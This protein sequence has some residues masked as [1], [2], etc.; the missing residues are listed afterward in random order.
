MELRQ[1]PGPLRSK[2]E[3][4]VADDRAASN[5][6]WT[7]IKCASTPYESVEDR[8][9]EIRR[10]FS[11]DSKGLV[12]RGRRSDPESPPSA[13]SNDHDLLVSIPPLK[14]SERTGTITWIARLVVLFMAVAGIC[15][16][17]TR[18]M[19]VPP[20]PP[21]PQTL[22][23]PYRFGGGALHGK[24]DHFVDVKICETPDCYPDCHTVSDHRQLHLE[25]PQSFHKATT[26]HTAILCNKP[27]Y[28]AMKVCTNP[29]EEID[30]H[31]PHYSFFHNHNST[32]GYKPS[33]MEI[34]RR[35]YPGRP[36]HLNLTFPVNTTVHIAVCSD[37]SSHPV[38]HEAHCVEKPEVNSDKPATDSN[39]HSKTGQSNEQKHQEHAG[40]YEEDRHGSSSHESS[41][42]EHGH[43]KDSEQAHKE[44]GSQDTDTEHDRDLAEDEPEFDKMDDEDREND[45]EEDLDNDGQADDH[46]YYD[47]EDSDH[48]DE[49]EG[50]EDDESHGD[51]YFDD[52]SHDA[53]DEP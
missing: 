39:E 51:N 43:A 3:T 41:T 22:L 38:K 32:V 4:D 21:P 31:P 19:G 53:N 8:E 48:E 5:S 12:Y 11:E 17:L 2:S 23:R 52:D 34:C 15:M 25:G 46:E 20:P 36:L 35:E 30:T 26:Q 1:R 42:R 27:Y 33:D 10:S 24:H 18:M 29:G 7:K 16:L 47:N 44:E 49:Q 37:G 45:D 28:V 14:S 50:G 40:G 9:K 13:P 6:P